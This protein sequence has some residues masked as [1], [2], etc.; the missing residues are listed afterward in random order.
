MYLRGKKV[1]P[2]SELN[3]ECLKPK[4]HHCQSMVDCKVCVRE[5][6]FQGCKNS[7]I[8][9]AFCSKACK[10]NTCVQRK[11]HCQYVAKQ[12][13]VRCSSKKEKCIDCEELLSRC[14]LESMIFFY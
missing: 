9:S 13:C 11:A 6:Q 1:L 10:C 14:T 8:H 5:T 12:Y 2:Q 4:C 3:L 7:V